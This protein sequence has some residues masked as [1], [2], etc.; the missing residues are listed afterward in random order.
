[1]TYFFPENL[2]ISVFFLMII[3]SKQQKEEKLGKF[4][5]SPLSPLK[6]LQQPHNP[7]ICKRKRERKNESR[8]S[9]LHSDTCG[10]ELHSRNNEPRNSCLVSEF[11]LIIAVIIVTVVLFRFLSSSVNRLINMSAPPRSLIAPPSPQE[12]Q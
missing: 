2:F 1:M 12:E 9:Q 10:T 4:I 7:P 8:K 11:A 5:L 3:K 6:C